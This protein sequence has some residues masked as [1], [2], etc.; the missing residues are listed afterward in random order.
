MNLVNM[1][2]QTSCCGKWFCTN[3][4]VMNFIISIQY[5]ANCYNDSLITFI[6]EKLFTNITNESFLHCS[7]G[8]KFQTMFQ[9]GLICYHLIWVWQR[10]KMQVMY[11]TTKLKLLRFFLLAGYNIHNY[12]VVS[13]TK[14]LLIL[15]S[16]SCFCRNFGIK[17]WSL[18]KDQVVSC[19]LAGNL[20]WLPTSWPNSSQ[21]R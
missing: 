17:K 10:W 11:C 16:L 6:F 18:R 1:F 3:V 15:Y 19:P 20:W 13:F 8:Q 9:S 12:V 4:A 2:L 21:S 14:R 5:W 7:W